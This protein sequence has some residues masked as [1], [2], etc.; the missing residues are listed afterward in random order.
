MAAQSIASAG[1]L[2][3]LQPLDPMRH[4]DQVATV[5][6]I[7]FAHE[8]GSESA[9][10]ATREMRRHA[11]LGWPVQVMVWLGMTSYLPTQGMVWVDSGRVVGTAHTQPAAADPGTWLIAN[12]AVLPDYRR[13]GIAEAVTRG[14]LDLIRRKHGRRALLQVDD[15]NLPAQRLYEKVGFTRLTTRA[16]YTR[17]SHSQPPDY[18][19]SRFEIR[20]QDERDWMAECDLARL[21]SPEGLT[22]GHALRVSDF[23]IGLGRKLMNV[24]SGT[25]EERWAAYTA[26]NHLVGA[27]RVVL[28]SPEGDQLRLLI[29]PALRGQVERPLLTRGL[30]RV[31]VRPWPLHLECQA[32]NSELASLLTEFGFVRRRCLRWMAMDLT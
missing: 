10:A 24:L 21:V 2:D 31:G 4:L 32:G 3:G 6:E 18:R 29:H 26:E 25:Q 17:A 1:P 8:M 28:G 11:A 19:P 20:L 7:G 9:R 30:R 23:R 5:L 13:R 27:M 15:D 16:H 12:V 14:T 22:W